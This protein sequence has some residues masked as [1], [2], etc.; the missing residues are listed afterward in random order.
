MFNHL[1][2]LPAY[3][4]DYNSPIKVN[5]DW[6]EDTDFKVAN[7]GGTYGRW[8]DRYCNKSSLF[9]NTDVIPLP[10]QITIR[11]NR[12]ANYVVYK[13]V[14]KGIVYSYEQA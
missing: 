3:G 8:M 7:V 2:L 4:R 11:Y 10:D 13:L 6:N 9:E 12:L 1:I 14:K 5:K